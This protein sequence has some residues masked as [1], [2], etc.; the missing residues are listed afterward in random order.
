MLIHQHRLFEYTRGN[1][2]LV[3]STVVKAAKTKQII[4]QLQNQKR[5]E[6]NWKLDIFCHD[7][8]S[9]VDIVIGR[10]NPSSAASSYGVYSVSIVIKAS[11]GDYELSVAWFETKQEAL[12]MLDVIRVY[13]NYR[14]GTR[15]I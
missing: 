14:Y 12:E 15:S 1:D 8:E 6:K 7:T 10:I 3:G 9:I 5:M 2:L 4:R 11:F 13:I